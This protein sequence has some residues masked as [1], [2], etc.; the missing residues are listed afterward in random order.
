MSIVKSDITK[1]ANSTTST[2]LLTLTD[3]ELFDLIDE[4][5]YNNNNNNNINS[6]QNEIRCS[7]LNCNNNDSIVEDHVQGII[8]CSKCGQVISNILDDSPEWN[9][10]EDDKDNIN[11]C[12][13][14]INYFL[15]QSSMSTTIACSSRNNLKRLQDWGA[16]PYNERSL[17][18]VLKEIHE[19]CQ[20]ANIIK[21]IE[22]DAKILYKHVY[23]FKYTTGKQKGDRLLVR[24]I[25][26]RSIIASCVLYACKRNGKT[27]S[28]KEI[29]KV[30][31]LKN[32]QM[33]RGYKKFYSILPY[34]KIYYE[35]QTSLPEHFIPRYC[36][37]LKIPKQYI[38]PILKISQN[39]QKLDIGS[40][41]TPFSIAIGA[42]LL[43]IDI[44]KLPLDK[45]YLAVKFGVSLPTIEKTY[46]KISEYKNILINN[47]LVDKLAIL[48]KEEKEKIEMPESFKNMYYNTLLK[49]KPNINIKNIRKNNI[50]IMN[51]IE[52]TN[53]RYKKLLKN[54]EK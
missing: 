45:K 36:H 42:I 54:I 33:T 13:Q 32:K 26:R 48:I 23:E 30:F 1:Y 20:R 22:D 8:V 41:H 12:A 53:S 7:G 19:K 38:E 35:T 17:N 16:M 11:R 44:Y 15:P 29:A 47:D 37:D 31:D 28:S 5:E 21:Y 2:N 27:R 4:I 39:I 40:M 25:N 50:D 9:E 51:K 52:A 46:K 43:A 34:I 14:P 10:Y 24:G 3:S 6:E 49:P 18:N